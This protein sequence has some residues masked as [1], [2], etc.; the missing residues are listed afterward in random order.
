MSRI[1]KKPIAVPKPV[2]VTI[3]GRTV[4]VEGPKGKLEWSFDRDLK[5]AFDEA[6]RLIRVER[7]SDQRRHRALHGLTRALIANMVEGVTNGYAKAIEIYGTGY[8]ANVQGKKL[9][10]AC[11]FAH[12]VER[13]IPA[14]IEVAVEVPNTRGN[15]Q[16]AKFVI[17]G[18]SKQLVGEFA[19][20]VRHIRP[21]EP[22]LGKGIRYAGEKI[23]RKAGKTFVGGA[24]V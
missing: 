14:G 6:E 4:H 21:P 5:V 18:C 23:R 19:A 3:T 9:V 1:G 17:R 8:S 10:I 13:T 24:A 7:P 2:K 11:G 12:P 16:P 22:Y 20:E 15:E